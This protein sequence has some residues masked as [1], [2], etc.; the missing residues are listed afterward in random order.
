MM[1]GIWLA[2]G[3]VLGFSCYMLKGRVVGFCVTAVWG[4]AAA[5]LF[6]PPVY[7]FR[8][9]EARDLIA[10]ALYGTVG[11]ILTGTVEPV[12]RRLREQTGPRKQKAPA[13][14]IVDLQS[15]WL[16]PE[17][18]IAERFRRREIDVELSSLE[19]FRCSY[20]DAIRILS[21]TIGA[22]L[23][24]PELQ[25]VALVTGRRA[26]VQLL[27]VDALR[28]WPPPLGRKVAI[29]RCDADSV[30]ADF[31]DWPAHMTATWFD[32]GYGRTFQISLRS[33]GI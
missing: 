15:V 30:C 28:S 33:A 9:T 18:G 14:E 32:N 19:D 12:G 5:F 17:S 22:A 23:A 25:R 16:D 7:S 26:G 6:M 24:D 3:V 31:P 20:S 21:D 11:L 27:F 8:V 10:L 13:G 1:S 4:A 29:G 2:A